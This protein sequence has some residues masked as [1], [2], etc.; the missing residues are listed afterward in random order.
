MLADVLRQ[1]GRHT[2]ASKV[3]R[4]PYIKPALEGLTVGMAVA[5]L[6][7]VE[8]AAVPTAAVAG[9]PERVADA[10]GKIR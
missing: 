1:L 9:R 10:L 3:L 8:L 2:A 7:V 5:L 4:T 6:V